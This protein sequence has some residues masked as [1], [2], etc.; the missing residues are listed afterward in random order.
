[1]SLQVLGHFCLTARS[2]SHV[3]PLSDHLAIPTY[4]AIAE[5]SKEDLKAV[6][7][8]KAPQKKGPYIK[9][10]PEYRAKVAKFASIIEIAYSKR[11]VVTGCVHHGGSTALL[12]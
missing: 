8:A 10:T 3:I 7:E 6:A 11:I 2:K 5:A 12:Q 9:F 4:S 1:M